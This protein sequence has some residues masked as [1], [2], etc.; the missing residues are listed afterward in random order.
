MND[1][2]ANFKGRSVRFEAFH[3]HNVPAHEFLVQLAHPIRRISIPHLRLTAVT[4][5]NNLKTDYW[6]ISKLFAYLRWIT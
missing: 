2:A 4:T 1:E 3:P 5:R 6:V